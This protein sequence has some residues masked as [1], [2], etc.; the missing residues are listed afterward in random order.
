M[1]QLASLKLP[2]LSVTLVEIVK[3]PA[4]V[5]VPLRDPLLERVTPEGRPVADP[6]V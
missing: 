6:Q 4:P 3:L 1:E 2:R 5:I